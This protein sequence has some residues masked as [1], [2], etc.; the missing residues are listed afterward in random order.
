MPNDQKSYEPVCAVC[1]CEEHEHGG[2]DGECTGCGEICE[3][4]PETEEED[5]DGTR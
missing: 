3:F 1:G 4:D 5:E 2:D